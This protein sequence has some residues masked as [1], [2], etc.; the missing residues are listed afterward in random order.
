MSERINHGVDLDSEDDRLIQWWLL[1][2]IKDWRQLVAEHASAGS[3]GGEIRAAILDGKA[4]A[5]R[6]IP[7]E[8]LVHAVGSGYV[9]LG[10]AIRRRYSIDIRT[11]GEA[12]FVAYEHTGNRRR[13]ADA[14][15][16][17]AAAAIVRLGERA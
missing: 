6:A 8:R 10:D 13:R 7:T 17:L 14:A 11:R 12:R 5:V 16:A 2:S 9:T 3:A 4:R 15:M 1:E